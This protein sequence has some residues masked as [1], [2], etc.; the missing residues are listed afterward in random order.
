V[1]VKTKP[2]GKEVT[3]KSI[4]TLYKVGEPFC[5]NKLNTLRIV[6]RVNNTDV[7]IM[8]LLLSHTN[9]FVIFIIM[10]NSIRYSEKHMVEELQY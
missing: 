10:N 8:H 5:Y 9:S 7:I 2:T 1:S 3:H 6:N 4:D